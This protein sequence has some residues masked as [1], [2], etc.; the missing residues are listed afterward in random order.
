MVAERGAEGIARVRDLNGGDGTHVVIEAVGYQDAYD[1]AFGVVRKGGTVSRV[2]VPQYTDANVGFASMFFP[3]IT[4]TGGVAPARAYIERLMSKVLDGS[5]HPGR[6][7][8]RT[9]SLAEVPAG[10]KA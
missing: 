3:N 7:F 10:Y 1:L 9:V 8:D 5:I 6:V 4:L 2:G